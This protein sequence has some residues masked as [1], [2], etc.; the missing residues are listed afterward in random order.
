MRTV[1]NIIP[2]IGSM[3][4]VVTDKLGPRPSY[5]SLRKI[6]EP[7]LDGEL[8]EHVSVLF[9]GH[10]RDMFVGECS[11]INGKAIRNI[12]ATE[13]YRSNA[14]AQHPDLDPEALPAISGPVVLFPDRRVWF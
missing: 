6:V 1:Y 9:E 10:H 5:D 3:R 8:L 7:H 14:L 13:I 11:A 12:R 4:V 2:P